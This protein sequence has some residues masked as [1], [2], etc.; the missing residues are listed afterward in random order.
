VQLS[1]TGGTL[2]GKIYSEDCQSFIFGGTFSDLATTLPYAT[3]STTKAANIKISQ[4]QA[5]TDLDN[6]SKAINLTL[7]LNK[8][9]VTPSTWS[10]IS[11]AS[12][13]YKVTLKNG[14][15]QNKTNASIDDHGLVDLGQGIFEF[16]NFT[17]DTDKFYAALM[18]QLETLKLT[19]TGSTLR[20]KY[21]GVGSNASTNSDGS[22]KYGSGANIIF[23]N[24]VLESDET[25]I[26]N[27]VPVK[28][29]FQDCTFK[30]NH[31][32]ALLRG[33]TYEF[34][35]NNT[36]E[37]VATYSGSTGANATSEC[38]NGTTWGTGNQTPFAPLVIGNDPESGAYQYTTTVDFLSGTTTVKT[39]GTYAANFPGIYVSAHASYAVTI[40]GLSDH[41][42]FDSSITY[43][44]K[45]EYYTDNITVDGTA[46][47]A[48]DNA[49][50][51][52]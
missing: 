32:G 5:L 36:I 30:G 38:K 31:Q 12:A 35:G 49:S 20:G 43:P 52:N 44:N 7:D 24:T 42:T 17:I 27:N 19:V 25:G 10:K 50:A 14:T 37:L 8:Q 46:K 9:T 1:V 4:A 45:I 26:M 16:Q 39:S 47:S 6:L 40:D 3:G 22:L 48:A 23:K 18:G 21:F 15:I 51:S 13:D 28:V 41:V 29:S 11:L 2:E 33:G 34:K